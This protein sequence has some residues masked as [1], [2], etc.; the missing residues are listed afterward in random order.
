M[1][2]RALVFVAACVAL[3][4]PCAGQATA[5]A[6][7]DSVR[8]LRNRVA[9][10]SDL[11]NLI[12]A[13]EAYFAD[14]LRYAPR[15]VDLAPRY[16]ASDGVTIVVLNGAATGHSAIAIH[17]DSPDLVCAIAIGA[18]AQNPIADGP[19]GAVICRLPDASIYNL[20]TPGRL[21]PDAASR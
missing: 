12:T 10:V 21:A 6:N 16:T 11:R 4:C 20:R 7:P 18:N 1:K 19:E 3:P 17:R 2:V 9:M 13:Q 15:M 8:I 5:T 14:H